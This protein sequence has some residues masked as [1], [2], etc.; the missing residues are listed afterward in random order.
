MANQQAPDTKTTRTSNATST[1]RDQPLCADGMAP[2]REKEAVACVCAE[3]AEASA[4]AKTPHDRHSPAKVE[5]DSEVRHRSAVVG[6]SGH[7]V[8]VNIAAEADVSVGL[9]LDTNAEADIGAGGASIPIS[10]PSSPAHVGMKHGM[11]S[12]AEKEQLAK[13]LDTDAESNLPVQIATKVGEG[14][15][16]SPS[17]GGGPAPAAPAQVPSTPLPR[18]ALS[19]AMEVAA[20]SG[21]TGESGQEPPAPAAFATPTATPTEEGSEMLTVATVAGERLPPPP[22]RLGRGRKLCPNCHALTKSA[23]KQ[24]RECHHVFS[25][26]SSRLRPPPRAEP[27]ENEDV[28]ITSRRRLRPSQRLMEYD[29]E[30]AGPSSPVS[31]GTVGAGSTAIR[32]PL[33]ANA[34][35]GGG[36]GV[37][38][39][40][41]GGGGRPAAA[42][43]AGGMT[44]KSTSAGAG[45]E[46]A[47]SA[48]DSMPTP[49]KRSHKRKVRIP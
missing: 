22:V 47:K 17:G 21:G 18:T 37:N 35:N 23:V 10:P 44:K 46:G 7:G 26:A 43:G 36:G 28:T 49:P 30:A 20:A 42:G 38:L 6:E 14:E 12:E 15:V 9:Q 24:C 5:P 31:F 27:T 48:A 16:R 34:A 25:P 33:A 29:C 8:N 2:S 3:A 40:S 4:A 32:R 13:A 45:G 19:A 1:G 41:A 11:P 39:I